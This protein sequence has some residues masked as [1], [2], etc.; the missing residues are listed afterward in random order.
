MI[1]SEAILI[2]NHTH[3]IIL[4]WA[5]ILLNPSKFPSNDKFRVA[6]PATNRQEQYRYYKVPTLSG[7]HSIHRFEAMVIALIAP[8]FAR[9]F[10]PGVLEIMCFYYATLFHISTS[11][12]IACT[13]R[14][15]TL[16]TNI[17]PHL[18]RWVVWLLFKY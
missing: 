1:E 17:I 4:H 11:T 9:N 15:P 7:F 8:Y 12:F 16:H 6:P 3:A 2:C 5:G 14:F 10:M 18:W 13:T